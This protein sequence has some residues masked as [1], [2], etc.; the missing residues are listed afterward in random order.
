MLE[1][2]TNTIKTTVVNL[3]V[4]WNNQYSK[5]K[6]A[7]TDYDR[8]KFFTNYNQDLADRVASYKNSES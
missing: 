4:T 3:N 7:I 5:P 1:Q 8:R 6:T 2:E